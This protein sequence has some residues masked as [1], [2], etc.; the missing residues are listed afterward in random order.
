MEHMQEMSRIISMG[1]RVKL[2]AARQIVEYSD[3]K[4]QFTLKQTYFEALNSYIL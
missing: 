2:Y 1:S 3:Y 4:S